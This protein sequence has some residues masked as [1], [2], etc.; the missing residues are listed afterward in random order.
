[1]YEIYHKRVYLFLSEHHHWI[2]D[3]QINHSIRFQ[4]K[5]RIIIFWNKFGQGG[6]RFPVQKRKFKFDCWIQHILISVD[7]RFQLK[8]AIMI[9]W[10]KFAPKRVFPVKCSTKEHYRSSHQRCSVRKGVFRNFTKFIG[11]HL[12]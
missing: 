6:Q 12:C 3:I 1:M 9:F 8:L 11:K 2:Q 7:T 5:I 10:N 4:L